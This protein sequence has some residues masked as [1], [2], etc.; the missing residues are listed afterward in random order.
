ME[1]DTTSDDEMSGS[2]SGS[3]RIWMKGER[4]RLKSSEDDGTYRVWVVSSFLKDNL[5][6]EMK[7]IHFW[8]IENRAGK[9]VVVH[10]RASEPEKKTLSESTSVSV[11]NSSFARVHRFTRCHHNPQDWKIEINFSEWKF[12]FP[13]ED[14]VRSDTTSSRVKVNDEQEVKKSECF[15]MFPDFFVS[16]HSLHGILISQAA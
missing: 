3:K 13:L 1:N 14:E 16:R 6:L 11:K 8:N 2:W 12:H 9:F 5:W 4:K 10:H 7:F 15:F